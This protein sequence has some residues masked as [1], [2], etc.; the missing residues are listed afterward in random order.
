MR[1]L[2]QISWYNNLSGFEYFPFV[3]YMDNLLDVEQ[4]GETKKNIFHQWPKSYG[5]FAD[6][7]TKQTFR[8]TRKKIVIRSQNLS[9]AKLIWVGEEIRSSVLVQIVTTK[10]DR[11][12]VIVDNSSV[13]ISRGVD[14]I[15]NLSFTISYTD[16]VANQTV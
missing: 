8:K 1:E 7:I 11:R 3:G 16:G 10:R 6:T 9:R 12:T 4:T 14:K 13:T 2:I 15:H 5:P